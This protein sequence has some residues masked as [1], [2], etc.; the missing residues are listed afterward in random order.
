[1]DDPIKFPLRANRFPWKSALRLEAQEIG[2]QLHGFNYGPLASFG[3]PN[4]DSRSDNA[5]AR[6]SMTLLLPQDEIPC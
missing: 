3:N 6:I 4:L 2:F 5:C 1:M